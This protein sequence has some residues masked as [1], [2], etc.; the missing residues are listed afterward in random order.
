MF[1][2]T[3]LA[4]NILIGP[5]IALGVLNPNILRENKALIIILQV[6]YIMYDMYNVKFNLL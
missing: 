2:T 3:H 1:F 4:P 6:S 5:I